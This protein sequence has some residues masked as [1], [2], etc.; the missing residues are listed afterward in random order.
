MNNS[1]YNMPTKNVQT[2]QAIVQDKRQIC[3]KPNF[4]K[5]RKC[6]EVKIFDEGIMD[7]CFKVIKL[8]RDCETFK[9]SENAKRNEKRKCS[10]IT[11]GSQRIAFFGK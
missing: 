11:V 6:N 5:K 9:I 8:E 4:I 7:D 3:Q 10:D 2:I 1:I